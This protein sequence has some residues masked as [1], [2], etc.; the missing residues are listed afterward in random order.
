MV[1]APTGNEA[2][3]KYEA[4]SGS[5]WVLFLLDLYDSELLCR[6]LGPWRRRAV[7]LALALGSLAL[8]TR[9]TWFIDTAGSYVA[10]LFLYQKF[11]G[12]ELLGER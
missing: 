9:L 1:V 5:L 11:D 3:W 12:A 6:F 10:P 7:S 4:L 2:L 8:F